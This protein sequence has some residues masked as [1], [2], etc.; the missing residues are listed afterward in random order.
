[1]TKARALR[2][3]IVLVGP[4]GH[5]WKQGPMCGALEDLDLQVM[6]MRCCHFGLKCDRS[7]KLPGGSYL[8]VETTCTRIPTNLWRCTCQ[9]AGKPAQLTEQ[10]LDWY[11]HGAQ[12]AAWRNQTLASMT[13]RL[14]DHMGLR[15]T[16]RYHTSV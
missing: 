3:S 9:A 4:P 1:M 14:I 2:M 10:E 11:V 16:Q 13:A 8:Q 6:R 7:R 12:K 5:F 15:K